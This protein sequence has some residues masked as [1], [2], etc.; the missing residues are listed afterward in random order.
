MF[1]L[2]ILKYKW[3][4]G[5]CS[6]AYIYKIFSHNKVFSRNSGLFS[7]PTGPSVHTSIIVPKYSF[8]NFVFTYMLCW[9]CYFYLKKS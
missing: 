9:L 1:D 8:R 3:D 2:E 5:Q 7:V 6:A 4:E